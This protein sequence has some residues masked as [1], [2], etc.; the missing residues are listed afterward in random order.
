VPVSQLADKNVFSLNYFVQAF[1]VR[2]KTKRKKVINVFL[3][4]AIR[5]TWTESI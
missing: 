4:G 2:D 3:I 1:A 5:I